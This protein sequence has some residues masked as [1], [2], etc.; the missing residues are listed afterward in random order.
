[1]GDWTDSIGGG[2]KNERK[3]AGIEGSGDEANGVMEEGQ[4]EETRR[5]EGHGYS[6]TRAR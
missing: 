4:A 5:V 2:K 6:P 3:K 1:M